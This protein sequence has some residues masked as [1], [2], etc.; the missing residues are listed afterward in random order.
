MRMKYHFSAV[1]AAIGLVVGAFGSGAAA[2]A[3]AR[4]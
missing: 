2:G 1:L 4:Y 3:T